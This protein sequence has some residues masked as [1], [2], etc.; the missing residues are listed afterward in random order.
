MDCCSVI[1]FTNGNMPEQEPLELVDLSAGDSDSD[2]SDKHDLSDDSLSDLYSEKAVPVQLK[3]QHALVNESVM[4][5]H[6]RQKQHSNCNSIC[7]NFMWTLEHT[8]VILVI[9]VFYCCLTCMLTVIMSIC[10]WDLHARGVQW[11][12]QIELKLGNIFVF[13][14]NGNWTVGSVRKSSVLEM[15]WE[16]TWNV[17]WT[18]CVTCAKEFSSQLASQIHFCGKHGEGY[19]CDT[20]LKRFD[21]PIQQCCHMKKCPGGGNTLMYPPR[22]REWALRTHGGWN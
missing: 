14:Q 2:A 21:S 19:I 12:H 13:T 11:Q 1:G 3:G 22:D 16:S 17:I 10:Q 6:S 15:Q 8:F 5:V 20:C 9:L 4:S 18:P 7:N